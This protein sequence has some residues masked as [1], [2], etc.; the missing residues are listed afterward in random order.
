MAAVALQTAGGSGLGG[1]RRP[2]DLMAVDKMQNSRA[3]VGVLR[4]LRAENAGSEVSCAG[5][6]VVGDFP[7]SRLSR[8]GS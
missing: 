5:D 3:G 8:A 2:D 6:T 4:A 7:D 1:I